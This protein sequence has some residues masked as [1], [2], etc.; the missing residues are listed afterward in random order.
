MRGLALGSA[1]LLPAPACAASGAPVPGPIW[2]LPFIGVLLSIALMPIFAPRFWHRRMGSVALGW[3]AALL[4][5]LAFTSGIHTAA[6]AAW[7]AI[8]IEYLPFV[9]LLLAL[10]TA[11]GGILVRGGPIGSPAGN[12]GLLV[13]GTM[14]AGV[15]GTTGAAM[16]LIHPLLHANAHR[17]RKTHLVVFFIALVANAG[18]AT[19][20][21]GDPPLYL[22]F[23]HGVPFFWPV[24]HL[25]APLIVLAIPLLIAFFWLDRRLAAAD[26]SP[27]RRERFHVRGLPNIA[28]IAVAVATVLVTGMWRPGEV[29]LLG[30][31]V[32]IA[33]LTGDAVFLAVTLASIA[34]TPRA[35]RQGNMFSWHPMAEVATLFAAIFITIGP[36][37]AMLEA[38]LEG[39]LAPVLRLTA[40]AS[41]EPLPLAYFWLTG[42]LSAFLDNAPTYLVFFELAGG[43]PVYLTGP[44]NHVLTA[45]SAGAVFFGALT[46]IGN[47]PNMMLRAIASH[48]GVRMPGFFGYMGLSAILLLPGFLLLSWVFFR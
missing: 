26:P 33:R 4:V 24:T 12:T 18:G 19:T 9:T 6:E 15:M 44:L 27:G 20:P 10:Y 29:V 30:Q 2:S 23:L 40:N 47:A 37:L 25:A 1:F 41:G 42:L 39:P 35:V 13:I 7:H 43:D 34:V 48:R 46:Y 11:A 5:P 28:L 17:T 14:L 22:G 3:S 45:I 8:L 21:L 16:V 32:G 38:G 36:V 31:T